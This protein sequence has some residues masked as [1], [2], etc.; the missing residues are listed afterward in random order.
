MANILYGRCEANKPIT[1]SLGNKSMVFAPAQ[2]W[3][4]YWLAKNRADYN[5][6]LIFLVNKRL[7]GKDARSILIKFGLVSPTQIRQFD[8]RDFK[9]VLLLRIRL[10]KVKVYLIH[11]SYMRPVLLGDSYLSVNCRSAFSVEQYNKPGIKPQR[12]KLALELS[13]ILM[14]RRA[15]KIRLDD[16]YWSKWWITRQFI[17]A[18]SVIVV[19]VESA[20]ALVKLGVAIVAGLYTVVKAYVRTLHNLATGDFKAVQNDIKRLFVNIAVGIES[21]EAN[22]KKGYEVVTTIWGDEHS[23]NLLFAFMKEYVDGTSVVDSATFKISLT[24]DVILII[25][26]LGAGAVVVGAR[27]AHRVGQ[28]TVRALQFIVK[29]YEALKLSKA[30]RIIGSKAANKQIPAPKAKSSGS[31]GNGSKTTTTD[32]TETQSTKQTGSGVI[33]DKTAGTGQNKPKIVPIKIRE[34]NPNEI[35]FSQNTVSYNKTDRLTGDKFTYDDIVGSMKKDGWKGDPVDVVKM[36]DGKLTSMDNTRIHA[37]R[38]A[39]VNVKATVRQA[40]DKLTPT[41]AKRFAIPKKGIY[42]KTWGEAINVRINKQTGG[43]AKS[44]PSGSLAPPRLTGKPK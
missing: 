40:S 30:N 17:V 8:G 4:T 41:E 3:P 22:I 20:V 33:P 42:P 18:G 2:F 1:V 27:L 23:R 9:K 29:L 38:E 7:T 39:G 28:F 5:I 13:Q 19:F 16:I 21:L 32:K 15:D 31:A 12:E 44:N 26:T 35:R 11:N 34:I 37:A 43:F 24:I 25:G 6:S 36:P 14:H 10:E